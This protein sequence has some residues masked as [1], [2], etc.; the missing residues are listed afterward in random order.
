MDKDM[1]VQSK[2]TV[3]N[4]ALLIIG[5]VFVAFNLRPAITSVGPVIGLIR[6]DLEFSNGVAGLITTLPLL[7][8]AAL[9]F[10]APKIG[11]RLGN[12]LAILLGL[13]L[14]TIGIVLRSLGF[15]FMLFAGTAIAGIGIA[16]CNVLLPGIVKQRF[17]TKVG[18]MTGLYTASLGGFAAIASGI[19]IPLAVN[20]GFGW[21]NALLVWAGLAITAFVIWLP[22]VRMYRRAQNLQTD[23][24]LSPPLPSLL[25]SK[26]AWYVT[27]FIGLQSF[28]FYCVIAWLPEILMKQGLNDTASGWM[29][30]LL[31]LFGLPFSF[32]TPILA[33]KVK[34]QRGIVIG[35]ALT[36]ITAFIGLVLDG[37]ASLTILWILLIGIAQG[38]GFSLA[39]TFFVLR[40]VSSDQASALSGMA[41]SLGYLLA[42][43][44][45][46]FIGM[47]FD[48]TGSST[49]PLYTFVSIA[50]AM[51]IAGLGA[52]AGLITHLKK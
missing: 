39:L 20:M 45:P 33:T 13:I 25:Q 8:F 37:T 40:T 15:P 49:A 26:L 11:Q 9:S 24:E 23:G 19:S 17:P 2:Q 14:L 21:K 34:N 10:L 36:Y 1:H 6:A 5:I 29:L 50:V 12:E 51:L 31:Q 52:G 32:V 27:F 22:Q 16:I 47:L 44:G 42:A 7:A 30:S 3:A 41:Q 38:A 35:I 48:Q 4:Q 46:I 18:L 43:I 28:L